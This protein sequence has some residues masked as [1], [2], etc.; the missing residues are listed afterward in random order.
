[1]SVVGRH[2]KDS[3]SV[4]PFTVELADWLES[5]TGEASVTCS[6]AIDDPPDADL[7]IASASITGTTA[8]IKVSGGTVGEVYKVRCRATTSPTSYIDDF[9][10]VIRI[11]EP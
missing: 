3:D 10:H 9:V 11:V 5:L 4:L 2:T 7:T 1:M 6:W 8:T